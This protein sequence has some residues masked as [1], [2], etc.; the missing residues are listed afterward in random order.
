[1]GKLL[2][3]K[4][5]R[6]FRQKSFYICCLIMI[7]VCVIPI[8]VINAFN[9][10]ID[11]KMM[12]EG[13]IVT[14]GP[15]IEITGKYFLMTAISGSSIGVF[16]A[17]FTSLFI[18]GDFSS[19]TIKNVLS[20]GYGRSNY[21]VSSFIAAFWAASIMTLICLLSGF[22]AGTLLGELGTGWSASLIPILLVQL[23]IVFAFTS[24][25][26]AIA[27]LLRKTGAAIAVSVLTS[28]VVSLI[29]SL[30]DVWFFRESTFRT[31]DYLL[32]PVMSSVSNV[33]V[34]T[35]V[36]LK[37]AICAAIYLLVGLVLSYIAFRKREV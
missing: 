35:E 25:Y 30:I 37:S 8:F 7:V 12:P 2:N 9:H 22:T 17:I 16:L 13:A 20:R 3:F 24:I 6:I 19:G 31:S 33:S 36:L 29:T 32:S 1:M 14:V 21:L 28:T 11:S 26:T 5:R 23:L 34:S 4:F 15:D 10:T 27:F 18:C